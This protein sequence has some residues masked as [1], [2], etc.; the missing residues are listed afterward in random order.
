[1]VRMRNIRLK[2]KGILLDL[3]GTIVDSK[4]AYLE[5]ARTAFQTMEQKMIDARIVTEIPKRLEQNLPI[6]NIVKGIDSQ[7]F[8]GIYLHTYYQVTSMKTKPIPKVSNALKKLSK[9]TKLALVTMRFVP[10]EKVVREL[11]KFGLARYFQYI[12]TAMDTHD[13][14][15]SPEALIKCAKKLGIKMRECAVVGDSVADVRAGKTARAKTVAV[16][17]GIYSRKELE[18]EKPDLILDSVNQLPDFIE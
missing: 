3:D 9:K 14:K 5:A 4:E 8:L 13:P 16:L 10:K 1:M 18:R 12:I 7:K 11:E 6:N 15:P 17:T 2:V